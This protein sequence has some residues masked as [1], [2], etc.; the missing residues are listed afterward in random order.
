MDTYS[1]WESVE[2]TTTAMILPQD[3]GFRNTVFV[4][5]HDVVNELAEDQNGVVICLGTFAAPLMTKIELKPS[6]LSSHH[7]YQD[8]DKFITHT[9]FCRL[10]SERIVLDCAHIPQPFSVSLYVEVTRDVMFSSIAVRSTDTFQRLLEE[11]TMELTDLGDEEETTCSICLEDFSESHD[12]NI[13]LLPD[14][15]HLFHQSCIFEWL[16]RQRSCPLCRRVPYEEDLET[17]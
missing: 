9:E 2:I 14:C 17:E 7:I 6:C 3:Q 16:K 4:N 8:L 5:L 15:F 12:D 13:I 1:N 11:Q 10:L